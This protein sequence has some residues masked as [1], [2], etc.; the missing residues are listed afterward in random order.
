MLTS[1]LQQDLEYDP[2]LYQR[3]RGELD[4][5]QRSVS[6][7][8]LIDNS[9]TAYLNPAGRAASPAP[10]KLAGY[11]RYLATGPQPEI[12]MTRLDYDQQPL[13]QATVSIHR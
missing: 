13:L 12:E 11:D 9:S 7:A 1:G 5:D 4:W 10:S 2:A 3:D 8:T 6:S